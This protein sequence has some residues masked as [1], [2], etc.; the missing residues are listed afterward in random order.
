MP[1]ETTT[2]NAAVTS[3]QPFDLAATT[4]KLLRAHQLEIWTRTDRLFAGLLAFEWLV[5]MAMAFWRSP[6]TWSGDVSRVHPHVWTAVFLGAAIVSMPL[7][8]AFRCAGQTMTRHVIAVAQMTM[9]GLLI[10]L[11][12]GRIEMHFHVF[13]SLAFLAFY[14]DWRVL[15]TASAVVAAD[16]LLR[17]IYLPMSVYG[18]ANA[19]ILRT[20]EH[21]GWVIFEDVFLI[22][23]CLRAVRE[24]RRIAENRALLEHSYHD[25]ERKVQERTAELKNAQDEL[26]KAARTAGM[27]EIATSVLHNVGNVLNSVNVSA[28]VVSEKLKRSEIATLTQ[29]GGIMAEHREDMD[30]FLTQDDRGKVIP[31]FIVELAECIGDEQ[32]MVMAEV[33]NLSNGIYH[34]K[35]I[36]AAQQAMAKASDFYTMVKPAS[37]LDSAL[38]MQSAI[39][40]SE[41]EVVRN[42]APCPDAMLDQHKVLQILVNLL[43]NARHAVLAR[44]EGERRITVGVSPAQLPD[45]PGLRFRVGDNGIGIAPEN[46]TRIFSHGFTTKKEGH[47]FGLHSAANAAR[48][49]GGELSV[50][51]A[52]P[53]KGAT[54]TLDLPLRK[55]VEQEIPCKAA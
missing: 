26:L 33:E 46:L 52:G 53:G 14:R 17:G 40:T 1:T 3:E 32:K 6:Y 43:S 27:A 36:V 38:S 23:S 49:M 15:I 16:H 54:F 2:T 42:D 30:A 5:A 8:L 4:E 21:A 44:R 34:I 31:G 18:I 22:G 10:H 11:G 13:G 47:G 25:V 24:M 51:S 35:Q 48:E 29:V 37:V 50:D 45:G 20:L 41:I 19:S 28:T 9:S 55:K 12:G 7:F 39:R